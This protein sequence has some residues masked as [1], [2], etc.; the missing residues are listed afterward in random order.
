MQTLNLSS[1]ALVVIP[2]V[3]GLIFGVI[4]GYMTH[5]FQRLRDDIQWERE[6]LKLEQ[7]W[8]YEREKLNLLWQQK[9][10]EMELQYLKEERNNLRS[11][12]AKGVNDPQILTQL[13][14]TNHMLHRDV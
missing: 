3:I 5:R 8:Q 14:N 9:V 2:A 12:L 6:K 7:Q 1:F 10:Q 4:G 11:E 13:V